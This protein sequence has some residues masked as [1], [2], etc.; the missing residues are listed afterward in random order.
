V[1]GHVIDGDVAGPALDRQGLR[2]VELDA[3]QAGLDPDLA[4]RAVA[5]EVGQAAGGVHARSGRELDGHADRAAG[6]ARQPVAQLGR[7]DEQAPVGVRDARLLGGLAVLVVRGVA[8]RDVDDGVAALTGADLGVA[9]DELDGCGDRFG[10]VV[11][12]HEVLLGAQRTH[13]V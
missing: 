11:G 8:R 6:V 4:E 12:R 1:A 5:V 2:A 9:G 3:A 10:S 7:L 13:P